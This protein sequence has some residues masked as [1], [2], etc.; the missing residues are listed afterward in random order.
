MFNA[1]SLVAVALAALSFNALADGG[2]VQPFV[3]TPSTLTRAEVRVDLA[4]AMAAGTI[5]QGE[6]AIVESARAASRSRA[7]VLAELREAQRLGLTRVG[8]IGA[9][10]ATAEQLQRIQRA[11]ERAAT[12]MAQM[13]G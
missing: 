9:P 12:T 6:L 11:G 2:D 4:K 13:P 10:I 7:E 1:K 8:E 3:S 5:A